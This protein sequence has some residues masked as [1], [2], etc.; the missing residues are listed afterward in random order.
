MAGLQV[1]ETRL[2]YGEWF[3][4]PT[5]RG[6]GTDARVQQA[7]MKLLDR[8]NIID[9]VRFGLGWLGGGF[10]LPDPGW[11]LPDDEIKKALAYDP[12]G[13][14][15]LLQAAGLN[16]V[17]LGKVDAYQAGDAL[18]IAEFVQPGWKSLGVDI[19]IRPISAIETTER[20]YQRGDFTAYF[21][22]TRP[23]FPTTPD[24]VGRFKTGG[25]VNQVVRNPELDSLIDAQAREVKDRDKR[26]ALIQQIQRK[27]FEIGG[28]IQVLAHISIGVRQAFVKGYNPGPAGAT[29]MLVYA[30]SWLD[31]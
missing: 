31:M 4:L 26:K 29:E 24:L 23:Y 11:R 30:E 15:Q 18:T 6:I 2:E 20:I 9:T 10:A 3:H 7:F 21:M 14:K 5:Y 1:T 16:T 12:Q 19:E 27:I 13:A 8:Q 17:S 28:H 22:P 25:A